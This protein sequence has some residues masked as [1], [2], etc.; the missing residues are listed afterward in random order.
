MAATLQT[1]DSTTISLARP[2]DLPAAGIGVPETAPSRRF[3]I[4]SLL[5]D[6][7]RGDQQ[8]IGD[9]LQQYRNYLMLLAITQIEKCLQPLVSPS[10]VV[11]ETML[12]AHRHFA[13]FQGQSERE[14]LAWLRQILL[15]N[16]GR[17][18]EHY[19]LAAKRDVRREVS[20]DRLQRALDQSRPQFRSLLQADDQTPSVLVQRREDA[21]L[22]AERLD[23]LPAHYREVLVLRNVQGR[24]FEEIAARMDRSLG[25]TRMLWLR[26]LEKLRAVYRR[27]EP[28]DP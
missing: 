11:Q 19:V 4:D 17:F 1:T 25:A 8:R 14:L 28:Y 24:S 6:A 9:L 12:R 5:S 2:M 20:L 7:R 15:N 18:V 26:A 27:A 21:A 10:D 3:L 22:L 23:Q 13:Q 16:L